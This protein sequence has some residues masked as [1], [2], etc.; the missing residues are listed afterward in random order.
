MQKIMRF[1]EARQEERR[2]MG[3]RGRETGTKFNEIVPCERFVHGA[4]SPVRV[5]RE[6]LTFERRSG[7]SNRDAKP[8][9][10]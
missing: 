9:Q 2:R 3:K 6:S 8:L 1:K 7:N 5:S 10:T 4:S